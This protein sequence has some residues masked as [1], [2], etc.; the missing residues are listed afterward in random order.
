MIDPQVNF[1]LLFFV[2]PFVGPISWDTDGMIFQV[3]NEKNLGWLGYREDCTTQ[4]YGDC[5]KPL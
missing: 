1:R 5:N 4:L 3:S 2:G